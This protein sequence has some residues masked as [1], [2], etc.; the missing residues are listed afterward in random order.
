MLPRLQTLYS[1]NKPSPG[2]V[3][4]AALVNRQ[5]LHACTHVGRAIYCEHCKFC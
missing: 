5:W 1:P 3:R 2:V 4:I